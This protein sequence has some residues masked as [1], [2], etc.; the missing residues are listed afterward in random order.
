MIALPH[1]APTPVVAFAVRRTGAA[2]GVQITASHNPARDNGCKVYVDGGLQIVS[3]TDRDR[4][5]D[6]RRAPADE[7]ARQTVEPTDTSC[8]TPTSTAPQ[9]CGADT[10]RCGSP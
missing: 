7:I 3:P 10:I 5:G 1:P 8:S 6:R 2:A 9:R 4:G